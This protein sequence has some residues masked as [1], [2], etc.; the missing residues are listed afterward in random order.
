MRS[1]FSRLI[2]LLS[3]LTL[4]M[5]ISCN[6]RP[7]KVLNEDKMIDIFEDLYL[8]DAIT[9]SSRTGLGSEDSKE[10]LANGVLKKHSISQAE[11]DSS[12][13][14]YVNNNIQQYDR[15]QDSV[16][17]R[18]ERRKEVI[19]RKLASIYKY[20]TTGF[21]TELPSYYLLDSN[22]P[23]FSFKIDS[24]A[25]ASF[26]KEKFK[27]S[28]IVSGT[29]TLKSK[30]ES[31]LY[32]R[33]KDTVVVEQQPIEADRH[34][35]FVKPAIEDSLL[36]EISGYIRLRSRS[37]GIHSTILLNEIKNKTDS[38]VVVSSDSTMV[39]KNEL[40]SSEAVY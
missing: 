36:R 21:T 23:I 28:F 19:E 14:W 13:V 38:I 11:L 31:K 34:Y 1:Y 10:S 5:S 7:R 17:A 25:L 15:I 37:K 26:E 22:Q 9:R 20:K 24:T 3:I 33:Y 40:I 39:E 29:D 30:V 8:A 32:F 6:T 2:I 27:F 12:L 16:S 4:L 18:L 35:E